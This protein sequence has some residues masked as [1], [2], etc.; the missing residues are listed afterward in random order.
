ML[1]H[2]EVSN[3]AQIK[4]NQVCATTGCIR[5][6]CS[7]KFILRHVTR[8]M[9]TSTPMRIHGPHMRLCSSIPSRENGNSSSTD[10]AL[11]REATSARVTARRA[12]PLRPPRGGRR[13]EEPRKGGVWISEGWALHGIRRWSSKRS[14]VQRSACLPAHNSKAYRAQLPAVVCRR[15]RGTA[16][17]M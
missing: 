15:S 17:D 13:R 1:T 12:P 16:C 7:K 6:K 2:L 4:S 5:P 3:K 11:A 9:Y 10:A 14:L 8:T